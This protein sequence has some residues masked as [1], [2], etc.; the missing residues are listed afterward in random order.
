M[1]TRRTRS[2]RPSP[3]LRSTLE[4][5]IQTILPAD[6]TY[7]TAKLL[8]SV[9]HR[10]IPDWIDT[11]RKIIVEGKG[12][13]DGNDRRK[14]KLIKAA[15]PEYRII[16]VFSDPKRKISKTSKTSYSAWCDKQGI[17]W[18]TLDGLSKAIVD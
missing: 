3:K 9:E 11:A 14:M 7:E 10:Y 1:R 5:K 18:T 4:D 15:H 6:F 8:Y 17:E 2:K 16:M 13:F 12:F